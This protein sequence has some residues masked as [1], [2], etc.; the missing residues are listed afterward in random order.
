MKGYT[1]TSIQYCV[2]L[3]LAIIGWFEWRKNKLS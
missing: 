1:I 2:F 3:V